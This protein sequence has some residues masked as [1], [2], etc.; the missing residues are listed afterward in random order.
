[1]VHTLF[2]PPGGT[3][4]LHTTLGPGSHAVGHI[5]TLGNLTAWSGLSRHLPSQGL[6]RQQAIEKVIEQMSALATPGTSGFNWARYLVL[7]LGNLPLAR[8]IVL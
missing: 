4:P 1:M 5:Q 8:G 6:K 7:Q 2:F 3:R